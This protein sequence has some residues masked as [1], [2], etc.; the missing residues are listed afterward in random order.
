VQ[1]TLHATPSEEVTAFATASSELDLSSLR[2]DYHDF[3]DVFSEQEA[4]NLPPH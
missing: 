3:A 2:S 1:Y 4:Y